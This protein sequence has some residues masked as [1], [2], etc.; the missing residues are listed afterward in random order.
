MSDLDVTLPLGGRLVIAAN[1]LLGRAETPAS[2]AATA[3]LVDMLDAWDGIGLF[4]IAGG[5]VDPGDERNTRSAAM[6]AHPRLSRA[7]EAFTK[8]AGRQVVVLP[9]DADA[10]NVTVETGAGERRVRIQAGPADAGAVLGGGCAGVVTGGCEPSFENRNVAF[11]AS[12]G[13]VGEVV[14]RRR[15]R[16]GLP[17]VAVPTRVASWVE[18]EAGADLHARLWFAQVDLPG[19]SIWARLV[20]RHTERPDRPTRVAVF[21]GGDSWPEAEARMELPTRVRRRAAFLIALAGV[22]DILSAITPPLETRLKGLLDLVPLAVPQTATALVTVAGLGLLALARGVR[23]GQARAY[24]V[25]MALLLGSVALHVVKGVDLE[26]GATAAVVAVYLFVHRRAFRTKNRPRAIRHGIAV[27]LGAL[28]AVIAGVAASIEIVT[29]AEHRRVTLTDALLATVERLVGRHT[30]TLPHRLDDFASPMLIAVAL[31]F[32]AW[33]AW[34]AI[35]PAAARRG[36]R[37]ELHHARV[38]VERYGGGT[39]DYFAL[40]SDKQFFFWQE[41]LVAYAVHQSV[42]LVSPDPI[43]PVWEREDAWDAFRA[44]A[45]GE[46]WTVGAL[47]AHEDW[48]P[49]Y[50]RSG[51]HDLYVGDEAVVD[52]TRFSLEG[53]RNKGLRQARNRI[54]NHGYTMTFHDPATADDALRASVEAVMGLSRRGDVERGFSMTLGRI[55]DG[56]DKGLLLAVCRDPNGVPVAFCQYVP[57]PGI[58]GYSLDLMRRDQGEHPNGL[59]EFV[60]I[61]TILHLAANGYRKLGLNFATMRAVLAGETGAGITARVE[62]WALLRMGGSMQIES[63]WKFNAKFDPEWQPRYALYDTVGNVVP[64]AFAIA[65]AESWWELPLIGRFLVPPATQAGT[66]PV[67][68]P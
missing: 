32:V 68:Q 21:P 31:V 55:F 51:M 10:L 58:K 49:I 19:A 64:I 59:L 54:A 13:R 62:R 14:E 23:R 11:V 15:A 67:A 50:R 47:G 41:T 46:G 63:L 44:F 16:L 35:R 7:M 39:L 26:E 53:G 48:L 1:L 52:V 60:L 9:D 45:D 33:V 30:V 28:A 4:V 65:R 8:A 17:D 12:T 25:A 6:A 3:E 61:E 42:C 2:E 24:R 43:G 38:L 34:Q 5:L 18:V 27:G 22:L 36:T 20:G 37:D 56:D 66:T 29:A 40:R 57:A